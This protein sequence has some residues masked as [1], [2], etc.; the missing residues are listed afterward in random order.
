MGLVGLGWVDSVDDK[1]IDD[2]M[3]RTGKG[4]VWIAHTMPSTAARKTKQAQKET[5]TGGAGGQAIDRRTDGH[6]HRH[7]QRT[8]T[9]THAHTR[10]EVDKASKNADCPTEDRLTGLA[11]QSI[12]HN[13]CYWC[14]YW[15]WYWT[16]Q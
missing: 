3:V 16:I 8:D 1:S 5:M 14:W 6:T 13:Y 11:R 7:R 10:R 12:W 2:G 4:R 15:C 9:D